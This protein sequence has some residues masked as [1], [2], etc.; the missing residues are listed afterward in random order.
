METTQIHGIVNEVAEQSMGKTGIAVVDTNSLVAMGQAVL[1]SQ[2]NTENFVNTLILR[3]GRTIIDYRMYTSRLRPLVFDK[4]T[5]GIIVQKVKTAMPK[6]FEDK[7]YDLEDGDSIDM[8]V[9][10]KPKVNQKFFVNRTPYSFGITI[11]R[12]QLKRAFT[13]EVAFSAFL[14]SIF[15]EVRNAMELGF[16]RLGY[17]TMANYMVNT[18]DTQRV[19]L[20]TEFNALGL[21]DKTLTAANAQY[22]SEFQ[23]YAV[24]RFNTMAKKLEDM[25]VEYNAEGEERHSPLKRQRFI[26]ETEFMEALRTT[27]QWEAFNEKYV[28]K[29]NTIEVNHWQNPKEPRQIIATDETGS[30]ETMSNIV[31]FM[32]DTEALGVY[33]KEEEVLTTPV[34]ARGRYYNTFWHLE[35]MWMNDM[36]ENGI[37]FLLD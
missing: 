6:A 10:M 30:E 3:I 4:L 31:A 34:N 27:V 18:A 35:Q 15:G 22:N 1:S 5:W 20:L 32:H 8:F 28:E 37:V 14:S 36:S 9:I 16:E 25:S 13:D 33:L 29:V 11:Q 26:A 19:H 12:W 23:R 24:G 21:V 17:A 7:A 2:N